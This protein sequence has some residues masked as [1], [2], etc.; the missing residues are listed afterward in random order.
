MHRLLIAVFFSC[1]LTIYINAQEASLGYS[2]PANLNLNKENTVG[3]PFFYHEYSKGSIQLLDGKK[4]EDLNLKLNLQRQKILVALYDG[5]E[6]EITSPIS[7]V[8][9]YGKNELKPVIFLSGL[10]INGKQNERSI[11]QVLDSGKVMLLKYTK[12]RLENN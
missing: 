10:P 4:Y 6:V 1:V 11:Y 8:T 12:V 2:S 7:K 5:V 3:S 9:L